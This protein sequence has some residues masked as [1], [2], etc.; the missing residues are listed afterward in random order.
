MEFLIDGEMITDLIEV[1]NKE[2]L[3]V[4]LYSSP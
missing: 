3:P 4:N 1:L 2:I